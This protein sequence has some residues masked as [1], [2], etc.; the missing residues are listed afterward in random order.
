MT[1]DMTRHY[2]D[3]TGINIP[4]GVLRALVSAAEALLSGRE[5]TDADGL[6]LKNALDWLDARP[7]YREEIREATE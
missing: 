5:W 7:L 6:S 1:R 3:T 2:A 4:I